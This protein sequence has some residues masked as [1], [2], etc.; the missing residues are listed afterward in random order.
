[1]RILNLLLVFIYLFKQKIVAVLFAVLAVVSADVSHLFDNSDGYHYPKPDI[2]F[3]PKCAAGEIGEYPNCHP[4]A[5]P[6]PTRPPQCPQGKFDWK[7]G[8][9]RI[10]SDE[11]LFISLLFWKGYLGQYPNCQRPTPP[12]SCPPGYYGQYPK[13]ELPPTRPTPPPQCPPGF[14]GQ[15]PSCTRPTPPP[16]QPPTV[17]CPPGMIQLCPNAIIRLI[18]W[19]FKLYCLVKWN[20]RIYN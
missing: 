11:L 1:M 17:K 14:V 18:V 16:T 8:I 3:P 20:D 9:S 4:P 19:V 13:C 5:T 15:Y 6:P 12:P 7:T 10:S 2:P